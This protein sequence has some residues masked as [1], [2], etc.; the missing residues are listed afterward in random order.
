MSSEGKLVSEKR[1]KECE[2]VDF[3]ASGHVRW[4]HRVEDCNEQQRGDL[5]GSTSES[6]GVV[7]GSN[8]ELTDPAQ[9]RLNHFTLGKFTSLIEQVAF[10]T[11]L[12]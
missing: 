7:I 9:E 12:A 11:E 1:K 6:A 5:C 10:A 3:Q 2:D 4:S 8:R